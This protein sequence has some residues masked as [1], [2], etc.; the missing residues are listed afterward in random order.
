MSEIEKPWSQHKNAYESYYLRGLV[1]TMILK[2]HKG[3]LEDLNKSIQLLPQFERAYYFRGRVKDQIGDDD[4]G[5]IA[6]YQSKNGIAV[7]ALASS[8]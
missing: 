5:A 1:K 4:K 7:T 2:D 6:D 8:H 3:A